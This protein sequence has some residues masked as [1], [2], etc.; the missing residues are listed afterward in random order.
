MY[1]YEWYIL[2]C[3]LNQDRLGAGGSWISET[4]PIFRT[5]HLT[6]SKEAL[7]CRRTFISK[8]FQ[9]QTFSVTFV[10]LKAHCKDPKSYESSKEL[11]PT[12]Y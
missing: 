10:L 8:K 4:S 5:T 9:S 12:V 6:F 2:N 1:I 11:L 3:T 7:Y